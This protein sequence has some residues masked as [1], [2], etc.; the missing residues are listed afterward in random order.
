MM[1]NLLVILLALCIKS[2]FAVS[3]VDLFTFEDSFDCNDKF[4]HYSFCSAVNIKPWKESE[5]ALVR[6]YLS[7]LKSEKLDH[8]YQT[9]KD[10]GIHKFHRIE[11]GARWYNDHAN[12][13]VL[14]SRSS[15][16]ALL[17]VNPVIR[18]IGFS[19]RFFDNEQ[20]TDPY[21]P[22]PKKAL[23]VFHELVHNFD[24]AQDHISN[25]SQIQK[26][27]GWTWNGK[28][29]VIDG[30]DHAKAKSDFD[31]LIK[32]SKDGYRQ[33]SYNLMREKGIELGLPSLY[34]TFNTHE[35]FAEILTYFV[36]D[37]YAKHYLSEEVQK[38]LDDVVLNFS[39]G[40]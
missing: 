2:A 27:I 21:S 16:N 17:W 6:K 10:K 34:S 26:A 19:D 30:L 5:K 29:F 18:M 38:V 11:Y 25:N 36:F 40:Q 39:K 23:N 31:N 28:D 4:P 15:E 32:L 20:R 33:L 22:L 12:R 3:A 13:K 8:F 14:F 35:C 24:I 7:M 9:I 37:P 1:R